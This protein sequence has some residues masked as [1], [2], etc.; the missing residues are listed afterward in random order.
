MMNGSIVW[1]NDQDSLYTWSRTEKVC[2]YIKPKSIAR[3]FNNTAA[4]IHTHLGGLVEGWLIQV[5][6]LI[7]LLLMS[8]LDNRAPLLASKYNNWALM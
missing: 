4:K 1:W 5:K 8:S 3:L 6:Q 7:F 2:G